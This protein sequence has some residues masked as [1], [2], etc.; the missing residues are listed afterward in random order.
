MSATT[1]SDLTGE[2]KKGIKRQSERSF[3]IVLA[4][5]SLTYALI[6]IVITFPLI[7]DFGGSIVATAGDPFGALYSL[8][9]SVREPIVSAFPH[10]PV[11]VWTGALLTKFFGEVVAYNLMVLSGFVLGGAA[12]FAL[13]YRLTRSVSGS[14][15]AGLI[16]M[17]SPYHVAQALQHVGLANLHWIILF[18]LALLWFDEKP[19]AGRGVIFAISFAVTMLD[20]YLYGIF[21]MLIVALFATWRFGLWLAHSQ[22]KPWHRHQWASL[23][24]SLALGFALIIPALYPVFG[25]LTAAETKSVELVRSGSSSAELAAFSARGFA[26][27]TPPPDNILFGSQ[28]RPLYEEAAQRGTN[29]TE[30]SLYLGFST[31]ILALVGIVGLK[32]TPIIH[33][34]ARRW[35]SFWILLAVV[36]LYFSFAPTMNLLGLEV[37]APGGLLFEFIPLLRVYSRFG[38]LVLIPTTILAGFGVAWIAARIRSTKARWATIAMIAMVIVSDL[39]ALPSDRVVA[40]D[41]QHAP[42]VYQWLASSEAGSVGS[43]VEY[44]LVPPAEPDGYSYQLWAR[45]QPHHSINLDYAQTGDSE[46]RAQL[47]DLNRE[48]TLGRLRAKGVTHVLIHTEKY[49]PQMAIK[50]PLEYHGG[51]PVYLSPSEPGV[52][53]EGTFGT[54]NVYRI[55]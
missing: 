21:A 4:I 27:V 14:F 19:S 3:W 8:W 53:I 33:P 52:F 34:R 10:A 22:R 6:G 12:T 15:I 17:L 49:T 30:L 39:L 9:L 48:D 50:Y 38:L 42:A 41:A 55:Q 36:A 51:A 47:A 54:T 45:I 31:I 7:L 23:A 18:L 43:I 29:V 16:L 35:A 2:P 32:R 44:P 40:V 24:L 46:E 37:S 25:S 20:S 1:T 26:Y 5:A 28:T 13:V 11:L